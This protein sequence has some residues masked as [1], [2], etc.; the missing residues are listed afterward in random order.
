MTVVGTKHDT[1]VDVPHVDE[2]FPPDR[3]DEVLDEADYLVLACPLTD[4]TRGLVGE[5]E[6]SRLDSDAVLVNISRGEVV[7]EAALVEALQ[8]GGIR[9]AALDVFE[10]EPLPAESPLRSMSNVVMTPHVAGSTPY[11]FDRA[12]GLFADNLRR[13][14]DGGVDDLRNRIR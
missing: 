14:G 4:E 1:S 2:L 9:G 6:L 10:E 8:S 5:S 7:D 3:L 13:Y 11:Y 12:I